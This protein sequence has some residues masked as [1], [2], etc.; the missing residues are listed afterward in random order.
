MILPP[1]PPSRFL[2][3][4]DNNIVGVAR[5][6][7]QDHASALRE[8]LTL[9][10]KVTV[11]PVYLSVSLELDSRISIRSSTIHEGKGEAHRLRTSLGCD[12]EVYVI[13]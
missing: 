12:V 13:A 2:G 5:T 11:V 4:G 7:R 9:R 6:V 3:L 1:G 8:L 10:N